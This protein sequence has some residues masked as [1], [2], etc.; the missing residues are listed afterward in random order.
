MSPDPSDGQ[1]ARGEAG[2]LP[3]SAGYAR[4]S[5]SVAR[6]ARK[7][8]MTE[9]ATCWPCCVK[10][11]MKT[12]AVSK[13][14]RWAEG[15]WHTHTGRQGTLVSDTGAAGHGSTRGCT[16]GLAPCRDLT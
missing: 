3:S 16:V 12:K 15:T 13:L 2:Q 1:D 10:Y 14:S 6:V 5:S 9:R 8:Q 7:R 4:H 11:R